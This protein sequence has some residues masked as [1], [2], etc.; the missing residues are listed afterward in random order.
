MAKN[1]VIETKDLTKKFGD[2]TAVDHVN[3]SIEEGTIYG[4]LGPNGSGKTTTMK[5]LC[6]LLT[7]TS[8]VGLVFGKDLATEGH[9][10]KK[11]VGYMSQK[12]SLYPD[13]TVLENLNFYSGLYGLKGQEKEERIQA[14][15][16]LAGLVDREDELTGNLSGGWRQRLALG[17]SIL[18]KPKILLLDEPTSGVDPKA[19]RL[20]WDIIYK[21]SAEGTTIMVTTHFMDESEHCDKVAFIYFGGLIA[22]DTPENL[23]QMIPG[24]LYEIDAQD[25]MQVLAQIQ[26][27]A[28]GEV[29]DAYFHGEKCRVLVSEDRDITKEKFFENLDVKKIA[30]SMEDVFAYMVKAQSNKEMTD[31]RISG[32]GSTKLKIRTD[33]SKEA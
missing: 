2:F 7:P 20:F 24:S 17:C 16:E 18:H 6:G 33:K 3:I 25:G 23:K 31:G 32:T 19:R 21:L 27:G 4:F 5:L 12:F 26:N 13:M 15:L 14:M 1:I 28:I 22:I 30:P 11:D 9:D 29:M 8:G 10:I